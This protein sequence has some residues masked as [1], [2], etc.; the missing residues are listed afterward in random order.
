MRNKKHQQKRKKIQSVAYDNLWTCSL[1]RVSSIKA[2][3]IDLT[4]LVN[5][6]ASN[7]M[8]I[9]QLFACVFRILSSVI[10]PMHVQSGLRYWLTHHYSP[11][12]Y[13]MNDSKFLPMRATSTTLL[14]MTDNTNDNEESIAILHRAQ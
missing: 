9:Q 4:T 6:D 8:Y 1:F 2:S 7:W 10:I 11:L 3:Q 12:F 5:K 14:L 13:S